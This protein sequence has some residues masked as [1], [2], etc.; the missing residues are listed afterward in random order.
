MMQNDIWQTQSWASL[1]WSGQ[2]KL[3]HHFMQRTYNHVL[4]SP[5]YLKDR[6]SVYV[7]LDVANYDITYDLQINVI[8]WASVSL[9]IYK[10]YMTHDMLCVNCYL[11]IQG[12]TVNSFSKPNL[13]S[14]GFTGV[15]VFNETMKDTFKGT[16][17]AES[18]LYITITEGNYKLLNVVTTVMFGISYFVFFFSE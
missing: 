3:L 15:E 11:Y 18:F 8:A 10:N 7:V 1:E 13:K 14:S 17:A 4:V 12:K 5:F 2:W 16:T 9:T 6:I